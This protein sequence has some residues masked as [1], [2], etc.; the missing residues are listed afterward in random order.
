M[1]AENRFGVLDLYARYVWGLDTI[2]LDGYLSAFAPDG[3]YNE[4]IGHD[5]LTANFHRLTSVAH[6]PGSQHYNGQLL[7]LEGDSSECKLKSYS[8]IVF[9]LRNGDAGFRHL[10]IYRDTCIHLGDKWVFQERLWKPW[11][12]DQISDFAR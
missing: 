5:Q 11:D 7:F 10:G 1:T 3:R 9:R 4:N 2:D 12:P 6:W 8:S